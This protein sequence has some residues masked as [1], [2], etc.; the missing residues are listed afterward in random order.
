MVLQAVAKL[1]Y[2]WI[3]DASDRRKLGA[4]LLEP[5]LWRGYRSGINWSLSKVESF[6]GASFSRQSFDRSVFVAFIYPIVLFIVSWACGGPTRATKAFELPSEWLWWQRWLLLLWFAVI[7]CIAFWLVKKVHKF[8]QIDYQFGRLKNQLSKSTIWTL[9]ICLSLSTMMWM[10]Q[11]YHLWSLDAFMGVM[12]AITPLAILL[13]CVGIAIVSYFITFCAGYFGF[14]GV[15]GQAFGPL[16][17]T[18]IVGG[19]VIGIA[20]QYLAKTI[21]ALRLVAG[22]IV[23]PLLLV[24]FDSKYMELAVSLLFFFAVLPLVNGAADYVSLAVSR[25]LLTTAKTN[26]ALV[27][28]VVYD[29]ILAFMFLTLLTFVL[30]IAVIIYNLFSFY[31]FHEGTFFLVFMQSARST[32]ASGGLAVTVMLTSTLVPTF[33]HLLI[34]LMALFLR[35]LPGRSK[36][37]KFLTSE[38]DLSTTVR[39]GIIAYLLTAFLLGLSALIMAMYGLWFLVVFFTGGSF[40]QFLF[41]IA[42]TTWLLADAFTTWMLAYP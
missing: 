7:S 41:S 13:A 14:L 42:F 24:L 26:A 30:T 6:Y 25:R 21:V 18:M 15:G 36:I 19:G 27:R 33:A 10:H 28:H 29:I 4:W 34:V 39:Y 40:G 8:D 2:H 37:S 23:V 38:A 17:W 20:S 3:G 12:I 22:A 1:I 31:L 16:A 32:P 5:S 9:R 35:P 11:K